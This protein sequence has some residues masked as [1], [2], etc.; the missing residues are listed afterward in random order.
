MDSSFFKASSNGKLPALAGLGG[1]A[2]FGALGT[3]RNY[4]KFDNPSSGKKKATRV[5]GSP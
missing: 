3:R 2:F 5:D 1:P 4:G